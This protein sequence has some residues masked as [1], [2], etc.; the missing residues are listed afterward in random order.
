MRARAGLAQLAEQRFCK[1]QVVGSIPT[2][3]S[4]GVEDVTGDE[5]GD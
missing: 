1:P 3:G 4:L 5:L 2:P